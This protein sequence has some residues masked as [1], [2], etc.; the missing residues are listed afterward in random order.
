MRCRY[1][2]SE[3]IAVDMTPKLAIRLNALA[4]YAV[5][6]VLV[7]A[8]YWQ[9]AFDELPC[10]LCLLQRVALTGLAVGPILTIR[11]GPKPANYGLVI[12]AALMGAAIAARQ[13]LLHIMPGDAGF[14]SAVLGLHF[15]TWAFLCFVTATLAAA[16]ML[17]F[18]KQFA[19]QPDSRRGTFEGLA[20]WLIIGL[21]G[22]NAASALIECGFSGCPA[23]PVRYELLN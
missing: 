17:T 19:P 7:L 14:G 13:I 20:V 16:V 2:F 21:T 23:D 18:G 6:A 8:F 1:H 10:P 12:I 9:L 22:L 4:L 5:S 11:H 15:Y 3:A